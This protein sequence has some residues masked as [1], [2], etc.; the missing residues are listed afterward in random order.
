MAPLRRY[1][2]RRTKAPHLPNGT[3]RPR[4][5][6]E[7]FCYTCNVCRGVL[8]L[9]KHAFS[10]R[11]RP[12]SFTASYSLLMACT[13]IAPNSDDSTICALRRSPSALLRRIT[14]SLH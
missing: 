14:V 11:L 1:A 5:S 10:N 6:A 3:A 2:K 4:W 7:L 12:R 13:I 8:R 9:F